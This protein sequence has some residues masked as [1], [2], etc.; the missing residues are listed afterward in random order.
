MARGGVS[1]SGQRAVVAN[2]HRVDAAA[3]E[4]LGDITERIGQETTYLA[5][6]L[7]PVDTENLRDA[8]TYSLSEGRQRVEV[9]HDPTFFPDAPYHVYQELGF[10]HWL[11]GEFIHN[12]HLKPAW[13]E[14]SP[15][16][17][18]DI[19]QELRRIVR[20]AGRA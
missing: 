9:Y 7:A 5:Y 3:R 10:K 12:P 19:R 8:L 17:A 15:I 18:D 16:Y 11:S 20:S 2:L 13:D 4:R 1:V 6:Q 14:M